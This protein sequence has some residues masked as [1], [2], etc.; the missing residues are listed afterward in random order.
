M[1]PAETGH[2]VSECTQVRNCIR[3]LSERTIA[4]NRILTKTDA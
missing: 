3:A 4:G 1:H 2:H